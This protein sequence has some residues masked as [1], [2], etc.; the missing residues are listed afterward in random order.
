MAARP[1]SWC[2]TEEN[3]LGPSTCP[4]TQT[5]RVS[6]THAYGKYAAASGIATA[7]APDSSLYKTTD[8]GDT[9]TELTNNSGLPK[10]VKGRISV[11]I[12]P[13]RPDRVWAL[14]EAADEGLFRSDDGGATWARVWGDPEMYPYDSDNLTN[15]AHYYNHLFADPQDPETVY[16]LNP[17]I[18]KSVDGGRT[19]GEITA[20]HADHHDLWIDPQNPQRMING[21]DGGACVTFDGGASW[22]NIYNQPTG[23]F[24]H[25]ATDTRFPYRVYGTQQDSSAIAV[26]SRSNKGALLWS[27][28]Y[29][30]GSSESGHIAVRTDNP[31]IVYSGAIGSFGGNG[32]LLVRYDHGTAEFRNITAWPDIVGFLAGDRKY[33]W[34]WDFPIV[35]SPHDPDVLY[36]AGNVVFRSTDEGSS[37]EV[38]SPDLT[39]NDLEEREPFDPRTNIAPWERCTISRFAE[40]A[41]EPGVFW[42]GSDDGLV[43]I[44]RD[45][46]Q[47]WTNVT[48]KELPE[49]S[50]ITS[51][52]L[53]QHHPATA[54]VAAIRY[55]F[56]DY[57]PYLFRTHDYGQTWDKITD[58]IAEIDFTRVLREDP[59][60]QG[61]LYAGTEGGVYVSLNDGA[62]WQPL[63]QNLPPVPIHAMLVHNSDLVVATHGRGFWV[64]DDLSPL[65]QI[66]D[67]VT[68]SPAHLFRPRATYRFQ[69]EASP[70]PDPG[71]GPAK[72]YWLSL[73]LPAT[74]YVTETPQGESVRR[75]LDAASNPPDGVVV[76]YYLKQ[77]PESEVKLTFLDS[78]GHVINSFSSGSS[79]DTPSEDTGEPRIAASPGANRFV[80]DMRYPG[81]LELTGDNLIQRTHSGPLAPPSRYQVRLAVGDLTYEQSFEIL[82]DP[83]ISATD[84]DLESQFALLVDIRDKLSETHGA[85]SKIR[86]IREQIDAW[87]RRAE[88]KSGSE[89]L[90]QSAD[91]LKKKLTSIEDELVQRPDRPWVSRRARA[92][93]KIRVLDGR[94]GDLAD[95]VAISYTAPNRQSNAVFREVSQLV[96]VQL[97][98]L[99]KAIDKDLA[100]FS[101]QLAELDVPLVAP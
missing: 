48:P 40:S 93:L 71:P 1:G 35:A 27:D 53:S 83:R 38:I 22:S 54:Y 94:L 86:S 25:M 72:H 69:T 81:A 23:E 73:G 14:I 50:L 100:A 68:D 60:R 44:S 66:T 82:K 45:G 96:E 76:T 37:W 17:K 9:W 97:E 41:R 7:E 13:A 78:K 3:R 28:C 29:T 70:Y 32:P 79:D 95:T 61:L 16:V 90:I 84:A 49:W 4:W 20:P 24:Y 33:R 43:H 19:F 98:G 31:D 2:S 52:D 91:A 89:A 21:N 34:A 63:Q 51:I 18:R 42:A 47:T 15:R 99:R 6:S 5:I 62:S 11:A 64:L 12:S 30:V 57:R 39:R 46:G 55:Q 26:P 87:V 10:G 8:G 75:Y 56:G 58:G 65:H 101:S 67:Q 74:F 59:R 80:W 92:A 85:V 36:C 88:G 77:D